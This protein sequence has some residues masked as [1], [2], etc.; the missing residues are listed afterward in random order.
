[1]IKTIN[2]DFDL[3]ICTYIICILIT[4]WNYVWESNHQLNRNRN[5][6]YNFQINKGK[7]DNN[8]TYVTS[9]QNKRHKQ[10]MTHRNNNMSKYISN[11]NKYKQI[12]LTS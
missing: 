9:K 2:L 1:M 7:G 10:K 6:T 4:I 5:S 3:N 8:K 11:H 12:K